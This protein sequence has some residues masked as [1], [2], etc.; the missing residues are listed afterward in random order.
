MNERIV[1]VAS[2]IDIVVATMWREMLAAEGIHAELGGNNSAYAMMPQLGGI[3]LFVTETDAAR[4]RELIDQA[5]ATDPPQPPGPR[6][7]T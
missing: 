5:E 2:T 3:D 4:A 1:T 6:T 7:A